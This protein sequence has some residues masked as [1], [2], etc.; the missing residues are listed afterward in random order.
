[1]GGVVGWG[2]R[3]GPELGV[4]MLGAKNCDERMAA[5]FT[6]DGTPFLSLPVPPFQNTEYVLQDPAPQSGAG[7]PYWLSVQPYPR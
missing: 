2:A 3:V 1:M 7:L 4:E 5:A 6:S